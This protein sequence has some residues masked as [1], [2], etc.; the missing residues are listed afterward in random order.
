MN[1]MCAI[2]PNPTLFLF[3]V[4]RRPVLARK[5]GFVQVIEHPKKKEPPALNYKDTPAAK[6]E[7]ARQ[8]RRVARLK[9][10][11]NLNVD[12]K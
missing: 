5:L 8:P 4:S 11:K 2:H 10:L 3:E 12:T 1:N 7:E 9:K 6:M